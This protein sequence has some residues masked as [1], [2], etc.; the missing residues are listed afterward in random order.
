MKKTA[1]LV[2]F[3]LAGLAA[4]MLYGGAAFAQPTVSNVYPDGK[5][6]LEAT[7]YLSFTAS[8]A[9]GVTAVTVQLTGS[10]L[11]GSPIVKNFSLGN[12]LTTSGSS[13]SYFVSAPLV[14]NGLYSATI[15]A[16]DAN[17][18]STTTL[19]FDTVAPA[20]TFEAEDYNYTGAG[21]ASG[22]YYSDPTVDEYL[23]LG[24]T[25]GVDCQHSSG[26]NS[27]YRPNNGD[28][29]TPTS[30]LATED[31]GDLPRH[32]YAGA[33]DYDVGWTTTG[34]WGD[35]TRAY[36]VG[37][38][39][40]YLRAA[41][42]NGSGSDSASLWV[43]GSS[44]AVLSSSDAVFG[45]PG[46]GG[47]QNWV[48][49]P[50]LDSTSGSLV[51][52]TSDGTVGT[53]QLKV[54]GGNLNENYVMLIPANTNVVVSDAS[55]GSHF[56][57]GTY[58]FQMT[59]QFAFT[60]LSTLGVIPANVTVFLSSTNLAG[61]TAIQSLS[62][63]S[64]LT[65]SG[66]ATNLTVR[67]ALSSNT[68]YGAY[69]QLTD[70]N[71]IPG[72]TNINF[73]T[74]NPN[75]YS[76]EA[77]DWDY[78]G[79]SYF[80]CGFIYNNPAEIDLY[81]NQNGILGVDF[82]GPAY[83]G[84]AD[85]NRIGLHT[86]ACSDTPRLGYYSIGTGSLVENT[87]PATG[88]PYVDEDVNPS[89]GAWANYTRNYPAGTY[90]IYVRAASDGIT[91]TEADC[92]SFYLVTSGQGTANQ[93]TS[94]IGSY[95]MVNS[96]AW[97]GFIWRPVYDEG[98]NL[99]RFTADGSAI[100]LRYQYDSA[101]ANQH[102]Y[103]LVP[104]NTTQKFI[105]FVSNFQPDGSR[106]FQYTNEI[107]F[108]V[109]SSVGVS[110][111]NIVVNID[112][113]VVSGYSVTGTPDLLTV[114]CPI[115]AN[116]YHTVTVSVSDSYS[117]SVSINKF[118]TFNPNSYTF[119]AADYDYTDPTTLVAGQFFDNPQTNAYAG[120][121]ATEGIDEKDDGHSGYGYR[122]ITGVGQG[123]F[124]L[125]L[126]GLEFENPSGDSLLSAF[127]ASGDPQMD[128][129]F[130]DG[131]N[132]AN[133]T[134]TYPAGTYNIWMRSANPNSSGVTVNAAALSLVTRGWGTVNQTTTNLG[135]FTVPASDGW[136]TFAWAPLVDANG[137]YI[138]WTANGST[139][140]LRVTVDNGDY[141][142]GYYALI[143][144]NTTAPTATGIY[145]NGLSA[146]QQTNAL[147]FNA[148]SG[149][150]INV[151]S[152]VVVLNGVTVSNLVIT[153]TSTDYHVSAPGLQPNTYYTVSI[154]FAG[155]LGGGYSTSFSFD[156][157]APGNYQW[158]AADWD[159]TANGVSGLFIDNR[160]DAY[161][162]QANPP[163][164]LQST[165][166]IDVQ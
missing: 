129:G 136:H 63:A 68:V 111:N 72:V 74:I 134:R 160:I 116:G 128:I 8:S 145:P 142:V 75:Y 119:Q 33:Q 44:T 48:W 14:T 84:S 10:T 130:N 89:G 62:S 107:T 117:N 13:T 32:S 81:A 12:G 57:D 166:G 27:N 42:A 106:P 114:V 82:N 6:Q 47:W 135:T 78:N 85:D 143:P 2:G 95:S 165:E 46:T 11:I 55:V 137:N 16:T 71:G 164:G 157:F 92:G 120:F 88:E 153:G 99:A 36:P 23:N 35:Y 139:N 3:R 52:L 64:G 140:T 24:A 161:G 25:Y 15:N 87:N 73:D 149:G 93:G 131:G 118:D 38:Y 60:V 147:S 29:N 45:V 163:D 98:G 100:T 133:Y 132:W 162:L 76:V 90:N 51:T 5:Y 125:N 138:A 86:E 126:G 49:V 58:Q 1:T 115:L 37:V 54:D 156:T 141:N 43:E 151:S 148:M 77:L 103:I 159:Y 9:A 155:I 97:Q 94:K 101:N 28:T 102:F 79:G 150:G 124:G 154:S 110:A 34:D 22:K 96:G 67:F 91:G 144:A 109:V 20:F 4:A 61:Q 7:N 158:E 123:A 104:A 65:V 53:L 127:A 30:G 56:P 41:N 69:I 50:L 26:G 105:P 59:N 113:G 31:T 40:V 39:N 80:N 152:I 83:S 66:P 112:G 19:K 70:A 146:F 21:G 122:P 18:T 108:N 17:G 121:G